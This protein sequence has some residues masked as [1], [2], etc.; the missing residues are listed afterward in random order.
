MECQDKVT[1]SIVES[2]L[3]INVDGKSSSSNLKEYKLVCMLKLIMGL[4]MGYRL[5]DFRF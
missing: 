3:P 2:L 5:G 4:K 1:E